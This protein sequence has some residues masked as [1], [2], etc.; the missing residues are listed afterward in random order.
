MYLSEIQIRVR[1]SETDRMGYVYYGNYAGYFEVAR[2][3]SLRNLGF[4]YKAME[5]EGFILP[6]FTFSVK[7][8]R[9]AFYDD[10]LIIKVMVRELPAARIRFDY[11]TYNE[12]DELINTAE[13]TLVF[14]NKVTGKPCAAPAYF[15]DALKKFF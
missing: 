9:P 1:Y 12:K 10:L 5:D 6:V 4:T 8:M 3:E 15:L 7:Y 13:T 11:E 2:A 14:I